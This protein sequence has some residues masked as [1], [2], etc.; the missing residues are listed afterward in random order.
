MNG[1]KV[2]KIIVEYKYN[3]QQIKEK[4]EFIDNVVEPI[5]E[6]AQEYK[7]DYEKSKVCL[8]LLNW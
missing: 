1:N 6:Q 8:R 5:V 7:T 3:P 4:R 2:D